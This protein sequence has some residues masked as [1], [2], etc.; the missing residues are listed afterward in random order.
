MDVFILAL[1]IIGT[2]AFAVSGAM[3]A[4]KKKMDL[5]G[6]VILGLTTAIGGGV[7]RDLILGI[8]PPKTFANPLYAVIAIVTAAIIFIPPVHRWLSLRQP[9]FEK[10]LIVMDALGLGIFTVVGIRTAFEVSHSFSGF[11]MIFVGVVTGVGGGV[12]R[13]VL[14]SDT[15]Y[16]FVKHIYASASIAGAVV[17]VLLWPLNNGL[18]A[19]LAGTV[20]I[21]VIRLLSAH[22]KWNL[23]RVKEFENSV[24]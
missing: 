14:A 18:W 24:K 15:P 4:L 16:I 8:T 12:M 6:V 5:F 1:E 9:L 23:P 22:F 17:A 10:V 20:I 13:D 11:L 2:I 19:M 7:L 21:V 3:T